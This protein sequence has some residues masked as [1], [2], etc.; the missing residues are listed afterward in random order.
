M[1]PTDLPHR[2]E[3]WLCSLGAA[4]SG[5]PGKTRPVVVISPAAL[6]TDS[7]RDLVITIPLSSTV[8][9]SALRPRISK[10][11]GL[12][13]DSVAVIRA[14]RGLARS[15]LIRR[16]GKVSDDELREVDRALALCVGI[17]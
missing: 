4:R 8:A 17:G 3:I 6:L 7:A 1:S 2:G 14:I 15:R 9:G 13:A 5:E 12:E 11:S 16:L 10:T